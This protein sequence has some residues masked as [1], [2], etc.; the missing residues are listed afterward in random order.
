[1]EKVRKDKDLYVKWLFDLHKNDLIE[2]YRSYCRSHP[3]LSRNRCARF[4][5]LHHY[6]HIKPGKKLEF[7]RVMKRWYLRSGL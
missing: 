6:S 7:L 5:L 1:M 2:I 4:V 3:W